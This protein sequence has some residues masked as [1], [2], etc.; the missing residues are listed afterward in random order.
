MA[1][2][3]KRSKRTK[4]VAVKTSSGKT[5]RIELLA[6]A[7]YIAEDCV[8]RFEASYRESRGDILPRPVFRGKRTRDIFRQ[9][10]FST[11]KK[12]G[13]EKIPWP[14][15]GG[16]LL[17]SI[18]N[19][20]ANAWA[21]VDAEKTGPKIDLEQVLVSLETVKQKFCPA[22]GGGRV[23]IAGFVCDF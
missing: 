23:K 20:G 6:D 5:V 7:A 12:I 21:L 14:P 19:H 8:T 13:D 4:Q 15:F 17:E 16:L 9:M 18:L 3:K 10:L 1:K 11:K 2:A 22:D